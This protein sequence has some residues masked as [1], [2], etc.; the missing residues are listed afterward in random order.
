MSLIKKYLQHKSLKELVEEHNLYIGHHYDNKY[1]IFVLNYHPYKSEKCNE[2][3]EQCRGVVMEMDTWKVVA[4]GMP[5]FYNNGEKGVKSSFDFNNII[6]C[7]HK[8]DG[9][10]LHLFCY[11]NEWILATRYN[12]C[13]DYLGDIT[14]QELFEQIIDMTINEMGEFLDPTITYCLEMCS[15][16]NSIIK[17]YEKPSIY[18]LAAYNTLEEKTN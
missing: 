9:T 18:L 4:Y 10:L 5:R 7:E 14:Y 13:E 8:E 12:F 3:V 16:T 1:P 11:N 2:L 15:K 17:L 6:R